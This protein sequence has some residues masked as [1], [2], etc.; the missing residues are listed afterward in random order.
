MMS[1]H[2]LSQDAWN[3]YSGG[4]KWDYR[5]LAPGFKY[6]LTD[7]AA[8]IG[9]HQLRRAE[10]MRVAREAVVAGYRQALADVAEIELPAE[11]ADR[12]HAWHLFP[13]RLRLESLGIDRDTF[14][15]QLKAAGVGCSVHW[16]P[17]HAHPY[18]QDTFGWQASEFPVAS[19]EWMRL[20]SL[21]LFP[22]MREAE[23]ANVADAIRKICQA[24]RV[25]ETSAARR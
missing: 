25:P 8:A 14:M 20:I 1:L 15:E 3:R 7:V 10:P 6:N 17:L 12:I 4:G 23:V 13:I 19:S 18:Y 21:P 11:D 9:I 16:R 22:S 5:I 24:N 2:G